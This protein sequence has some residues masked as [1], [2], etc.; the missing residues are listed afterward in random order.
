MI[1]AVLDTN[2]VVSALISAAG[3]EALLLLAIAQGLL[4]PCYCAEII[5]EYAE[6]LARPKFDF[7]VEEVRAFVDMLRLRGESVTLGTLPGISPDP[8]DDK[9][10][11]CAQA[12]KA[13]F[14]VTG[15]KRH[16]PQE[17]LPGI[18]VVAAPELLERITLEI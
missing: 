18:L 10:I 2:V 3:N 8:E 5:E 6:V 14:L 13:E 16:F 7:Q 11:A 4:I 1:R 9:F 12:A 17:R 15:N